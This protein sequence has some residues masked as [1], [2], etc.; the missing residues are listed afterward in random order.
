MKNEWIVSIK[1]IH[2]EAKKNHKKSLAYKAKIDCISE[3]LP[4]VINRMIKESTVTMKD[5]GKGKVVEL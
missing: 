4:I 5:F 1:C 3:S 2:K